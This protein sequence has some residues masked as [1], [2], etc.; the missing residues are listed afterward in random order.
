MADD[1]FPYCVMLDSL[2]A[3]THRSFP[4]DHWQV[5]LPRDIE[6]RMEV[7]RDTREARA[8]MPQRYRDRNYRII[9]SYGVE[10]G[11]TWEVV[12]E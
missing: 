10:G 2:A 1:I 3:G 6:V 4:D 8:S 5:K 12:V 7:A 11:I 9:E